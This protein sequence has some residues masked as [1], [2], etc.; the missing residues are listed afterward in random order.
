MAFFALI[1]NITIMAPKN[2]E[3]LKKMLEFAIEL[4]KP[5]VIR[6][7][8]GGEGNIN[9]K[10]CENIELGKSELIKEGEDLTIVAIGKMVERAV[11]VS[12][13]LEQNG[14]NTEIINARFLKPLDDKTLEKSINKT[15]NVVTIED[16][17]LRGGLAT[18]IIELIN[19]LKLKDITI[20]TYGYNDKFVQ[21]GSV[22]ELEKLYGL[23][24]ESIAKSVVKSVK[25]VEKC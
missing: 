6:Y 3:E 2:F 10:K 25:F 11:Q 16:G 21:H 9:F 17:I 13:I 14:I 15:K 5:V 12:D 18:S 1:P 24:A 23:D 8:R 22:D 4:K 19:N 7:P 20:Q